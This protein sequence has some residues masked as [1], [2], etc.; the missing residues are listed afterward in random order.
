MC[1][2]NKNNNKLSYNMK[3]DRRCCCIPIKR[4]FL[5][6]IGIL[7]LFYLSEFRNYFY[8]PIVFFISSIILFWNF[9]VIIYAANSKP[10]YYEDL[11]ID[12]TKIPKHEIPK[13]IKIRFNRIFL[14]LLIFS[15]SSK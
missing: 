4:F 8:V 2:Q 13:L 3:N 10:V 1:K 11:F 15:N 14:W 6:L 5:P 7:G 9:P 12:E